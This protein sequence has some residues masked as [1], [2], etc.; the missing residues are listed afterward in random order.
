M[1]VHRLFSL[2]D[3]NLSSLLRKVRSATLSTIHSFSLFIL[4]A[5][6]CVVITDYN[7]FLFLVKNIVCSCG[8]VIFRFGDFC[9]GT[10]REDDTINS[11][12]N[13]RRAV[14]KS[15]LRNT[16]KLIHSQ[17]KNGQRKVR[18]SY[19]LYNNPHN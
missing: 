5:R 16:S 18:E 11:G 2:T 10:T 4:R 17:Y 8:R 19:I 6:C 14:S 9:G 3:N 13:K 7:L 1:F 15:A 12:L